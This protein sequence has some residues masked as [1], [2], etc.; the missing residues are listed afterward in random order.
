MWPFSRDKKPTRVPAI[1]CNGTDIIWNTTFQW[2]EFTVDDVDYSLTDNPVFDPM[3]LAK[4]PEI[5]GW[6]E[7]L[8]AEINVQIKRHLEGWGDVWQGQKDLVGIDV[9]WLL[10][11][12]EVNV[13]YADDD[14]ADL[15]VHVIITNGKITGSYAG[16]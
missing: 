6:L 4:L 2:W 7:A 8:D 12:N 3:V 1:R 9:S 5:T 13:A 10:S 14:W 16:D 15:G 11:K